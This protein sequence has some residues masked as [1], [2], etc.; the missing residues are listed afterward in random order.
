MLEFLCISCGVTS[1]TKTLCKS[2]Q[3]ANRLP[4]I[5]MLAVLHQT[6]ILDR[7]PDGVDVMRSPYSSLQTCH[8][9]RPA[10]PEFARSASEFVP[11][12]P[13]LHSPTGCQSIRCARRS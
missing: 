11:G 7:L 10:R 8:G 9:C 4:C 1:S 12:S 6:K 5:R 3:S 2:F 13:Q